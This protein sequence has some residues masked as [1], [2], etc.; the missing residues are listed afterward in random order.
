MVDLQEELSSALAN[1]TRLQTTSRPQESLQ[2]ISATQ[3]SL[4]GTNPDSKELT[5]K[6]TELA[7]KAMVRINLLFRGMFNI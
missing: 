6:V 2:K 7:Q 3:Q 5:N 1:Q 4:A